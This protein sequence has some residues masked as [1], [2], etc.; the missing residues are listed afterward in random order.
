MEA[1]RAGTAGKGFA[2][3]ADEVRSL[4][5]QSDEA[6]KATKELIENSVQATEKGRHIVGEVSQTLQRAQD[7][8]TQSTASISEIAQ[9]VA[10][11]AGSIAQVTEGLGQISAVVQSNSASS[12]ESAAVSAE[13]FQQVRLLGEQTGRFR[14]KN[15]GRSSLPSLPAGNL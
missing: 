1:A 10:G 8:V 6:A 11:E 12:E 3:V 9:A 2:V 5:A 14:L 15:Q 13:L 7:L 4:A